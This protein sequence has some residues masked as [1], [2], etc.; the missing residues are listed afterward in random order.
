MKCILCGHAVTGP[1]QPDDCPKCGGEMQAAEFKPI[2]KEIQISD[3]VIMSYNPCGGFE[4][5]VKGKPVA[6]P[7]TWYGVLKHIRDCRVRGTALKTV[8][9]L[10]AI[11]TKQERDM[12]CLATLIMEKMGSAK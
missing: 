9:E 10:V 2:G 5:R 7:T 4:V 1:K 11:E 3:D 6:F 8:A 12:R